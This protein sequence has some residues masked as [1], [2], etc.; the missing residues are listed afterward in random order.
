MFPPFATTVLL[1]LCLLSVNSAELPVI[2]TTSPTFTLA[3]PMSVYAASVDAYT[4]L[5]TAL[6]V[7]L[8]ALNTLTERLAP[9]LGVVLYTKTSPLVKAL[10][11][12]LCNVGT[13]KCDANWKSPLVALD[14]LVDPI[15]YQSSLNFS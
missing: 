10:T 12:S 7:L 6:K 2:A 4:G 9:V 1:P 3:R 8:V 11:P 14:Q 13:D 5:L 15:S